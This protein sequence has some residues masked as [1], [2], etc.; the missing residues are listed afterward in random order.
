MLVVTGSCA[1]DSRFGDQET[2]GLLLPPNRSA[3]PDPS[4]PR[5]SGTPRMN[6]LACGGTTV[7]LTQGPTQQALARHAELHSWPRARALS[8]S[9]SLNLSLCLYLCFSPPPPS[10]LSLSPQNARVLLIPTAIKPDPPSGH[11][12]F[13]HVTHGC[14]SRLGAL[15]TH[16]DPDPPTDI[17][18]CAHPLIHANTHTQSLPLSSS[19][20]KETKAEPSA[21]KPRQTWL[22]VSQISGLPFWLF[23]E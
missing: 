9:L 11:K 20:N 17:A 21:F 22:W 12:V 8:L 15:K 1:E 7:G 19:V 14:D 2:L 6:T 18:G 13:P 16:S 23:Q 4:D 3:L 10:F 5:R